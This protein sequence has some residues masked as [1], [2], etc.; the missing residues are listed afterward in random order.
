[1]GMLDDLKD[2]EN[3]TS[4]FTGDSTIPVATG[5][6]DKFYKIPETISTWNTWTDEQAVEGG[7]VFKANIED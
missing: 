4:T 6:S 1:M 5:A 3:V 2:M 7:K